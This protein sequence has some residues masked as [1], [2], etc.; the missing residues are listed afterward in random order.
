MKTIKFYRKM[1]GILHNETSSWRSKCGIYICDGALERAVSIPKDVKVVHAVFNKTRRAHDFT[2]VTRKGTYCN[3]FLKYGL[4]QGFS[5][6]IRAREALGTA[7]E[8]GLRY[9]RIEYNEPR[10]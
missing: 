7:Y 1:R 8:A 6:V 10:S 3:T 5:L 4:D 2:I 9:V